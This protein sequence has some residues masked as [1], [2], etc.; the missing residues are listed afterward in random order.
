L[1][2]HFL[3]ITQLLKGLRLSTHKLKAQI[4][5]DIPHYLARFYAKYIYYEQCYTIKFA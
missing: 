2:K 3:S 5:F 4:L 1:Y